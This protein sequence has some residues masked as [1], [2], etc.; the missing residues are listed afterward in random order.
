VAHVQLSQ[1]ANLDVEHFERQDLSCS[2]RRTSSGLRAVKGLFW[3][4]SD[5]SAPLE[6]VAIEEQKESKGK[7]NQKDTIT[8]SGLQTDAPSEVVRT[9]RHVDAASTGDCESCPSALHSYRSW[10]TRDAVPEESPE[11]E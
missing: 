6:S 11:H 3:K 7:E 4:G 1:D 8:A 9:R 2:F 10:H 5:Q